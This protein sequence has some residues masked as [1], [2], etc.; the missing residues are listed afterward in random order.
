MIARFHL[1]PEESGIAWNES[2]YLSLAARLLREFTLNYFAQGLT[3][4]NV[5]VV[6]IVSDIS[7]VSDE[8]KL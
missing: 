6:S 3:S 1:E 8:T 7:D 5:S 2:R 4:E